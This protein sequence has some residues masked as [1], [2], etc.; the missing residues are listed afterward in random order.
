LKNTLKLACIPAFNE[1]KNIGQLVKD[2]LLHVDEVI[3]CDDGSNDNT[4]TVAEEN[5]ALVVR[6]ERIM[7]TVLL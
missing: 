2:C 5:G 4:A 6:H 1:E 3:V 7:V